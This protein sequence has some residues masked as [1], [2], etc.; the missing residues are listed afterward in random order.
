MP[1]SPDEVVAVKTSNIPEWVFKVWDKLIAEAW[2][3][4]SA[5]IQQKDAV[6]ALQIADP[7]G[8]VD[9]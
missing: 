4:H 7:G 2:N 9:I 8:R 5:C 6:A 3:G 1:L